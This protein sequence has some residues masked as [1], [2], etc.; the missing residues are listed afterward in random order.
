VSGETIGLGVIGLGFMGQTHLRAA[1]DLAAAGLPCRV[2]AVHDPN[3]ERMSGRASGAGNLA[4]N[5]PG[6]ALFDPVEVTA[7]PD[8]ESL[9][10]DDA[11]DLVHVCTHT[12]SHADLALLAL[13]HG[14]HVL[15]EKPV[16]L[17]ASI[18]Q[19]VAD[20]ADAAGDRI[21][22][23][24]MCMRFWPGWDW[25][26]RT[27]ED[28]S[29]GPVRS[30][31]FRRLGQAPS[32]A[33]RFY[34]DVARSGGALFD[35]H[36]H[37]ADFVHWLFGPP[38]RVHATGTADHLT[39]A[40]LHEGPTGPAHIVAEGGWDQA[41]GFGFRMRFTVNFEAGTA[42]YDSLRTD[43]P[44]LLC[45]DGNATPIEIGPGTGYDG[46]IRHL[47]SILAGLESGPPRATM[48]DALAV[49][50][51]LEAERRSLE[52]GRVVELA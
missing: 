11:V 17:S 6:E 37:D 42:D 12:D 47:V 35:L 28:G 40:Y 44:L 32:W 50:L 3:P 19:R 45:R 30:A 1:R 24:A 38:T 31:T 39:T 18:V 36:I 33:R 23:P 2:V 15:V 51:L 46:E 13:E 49:T 16:A 52:T 27:V 26:K 20:A 34:G 25:L 14:R 21:C 8:P 48:A 4:A 10:A 43:A 41:A 9:L 29:L 5:E 22:M 7:H